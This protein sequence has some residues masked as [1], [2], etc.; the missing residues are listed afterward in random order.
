MN[1]VNWYFFGDSVIYYIAILIILPSLSTKM[2]LNITS[3]FSKSW[4]KVSMGVSNVLITSSHKNSCKMFSNSSQNYGLSFN[5][6]NIN[7]A[8][9]TSLREY[10]VMKSKNFRGAVQSNN[11]VQADFKHVKFCRSRDRVLIILFCKPQQWYLDFYL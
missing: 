1:I 10:L 7:K 11:A 2:L 4:R 6:E 8:S 3:F 5:K 9:L